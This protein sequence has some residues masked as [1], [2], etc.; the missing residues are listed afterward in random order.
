MRVTPTSEQMAYLASI[1][2]VGDT[3]SQTVQTPV[4]A[5]AGEHVKPARHPA[6]GLGWVWIVILAIVLALIAGVSMARGEDPPSPPI[7][8]VPENEPAD[9]RVQD[10]EARLRGVDASLSLLN[11]RVNQTA[12]A[13]QAQ[14]GEERTEGCA[15]LQEALQAQADRTD[16][17]RVLFMV[18]AGLLTVFVGV[19][20]ILMRR[21]MNQVELAVLGRTA[22][23]PPD[24]STE[25]DRE[26]CKKMPKNGPTAPSNFGIKPTRP[27][28]GTIPSIHAQME[29]II[30]AAAKL[31]R[32]R[33][34]LRH[35]EGPWTM[36]LATAKGNVR[37]ENQDYALRFQMDD[38]D[39]LIV[40][41]GCGG[42]PFSK[43]AAYLAAVSAAASVVRTYGTAPLL[44]SPYVQ[45]VAAQAI[46][47]A[48]HRLAVEGDKLN[49]TD[50]RGGL[51]TTLIVLVGNRRKVGYAYI[52][53]G[54]GCVVRT[55]GVV[56]RFLSPQKADELAMNVLA[57]SLGPTMEGEFVAGTIG[58]MPGDLVLVGTDGVFDRVGPEFP[59]DVLRGCI[60]FKGD[61]Q[62]TADHVLDELAS[63]KD[64]AG[65]VCDDNMTLGLLGDGTSPRLSQG[66]WSTTPSQDASAESTPE[67]VVE[68]AKEGAG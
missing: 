5:V 39:V 46:K 8:R 16:Q 52:G 65:Y 12:A 29:K 63:F 22:E 60:Q 32:F 21:R 61:L 17:M 62:A 27:A 57:A 66:F 36:G 41:D 37:P 48:A 47:D 44:F 28:A 58:R 59:K 20:R 19:E 55:N 3:L 13:L 6:H 15:L 43:R 35:P 7:K 1:G 26:G 56:E 45:D 33:V 30:E 53:D 24:N 23:F 42:V 68:A 2:V 54:G 10:L 38:Y 49:V 25:A 67:A 51:R 31:K 64:G 9:R 40:A 50:L 18:A 34:R 11:E 4:A 14:L